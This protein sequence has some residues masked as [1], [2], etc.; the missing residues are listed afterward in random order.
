MGRRLGLPRFGLPPE[1]SRLAALAL[2]GGFSVAPPTP[3]SAVMQADLDAKLPNDK[4]QSAF[5][6]LTRLRRSSNLDGADDPAP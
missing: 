6:A 4:H 5:P 1:S 2:V 3:F